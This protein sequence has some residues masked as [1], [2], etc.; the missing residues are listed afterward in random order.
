MDFP[1]TNKHHQ[2]LN[3]KFGENAKLLEERLKVVDWKLFLKFYFAL[4]VI[5]L[6]TIF[7]LIVVVKTALIIF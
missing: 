6:V 5:L 2:D 4:L 7:A 3:E 1:K